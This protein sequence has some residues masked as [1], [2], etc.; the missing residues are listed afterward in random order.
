MTLKIS[1]EL[2]GLMRTTWRPAQ[3]PLSQQGMAPDLRYNY[4][5]LLLRPIRKL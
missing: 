4:V 3:F 1:S 2:G 5:D